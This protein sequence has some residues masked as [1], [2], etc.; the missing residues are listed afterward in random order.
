M[1]DN[2]NI[3]T[4]LQDVEH[5]FEAC[6]IKKNVDPRTLK[7]SYNLFK[8]PNGIWLKST[9]EDLHTPATTSDLDFSQMPQL[10]KLTNLIDAT[11][12]EFAKSGGRLFITEFLVFKI[13]KGTSYPILKTENPANIKP[14]H[15][16][17]LCDEIGGQGM[18]QDRFR[19]EETYLLTRT[20]K[21]E[22]SASSSH[23][24]HSGVT[25]ILS[26]DTMPEL[27][28]LSA[29][30]NKED[31]QFKTNGG[32]VFVTPTRIYRIKNKIEMDIKL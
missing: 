7:E 29:K 16:R 3:S 24:N 17:K 30:L 2:E 15:Y 26:L 5:E 4:L 25:K 23:D 10:L 12:S 27:K 22:W 1:P 21:G 13:I 8:Q 19:I 18:E 6:G 32:R 11:D 20:P 14:E 9:K 31:L 28:I